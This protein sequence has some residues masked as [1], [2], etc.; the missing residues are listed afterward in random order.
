[1]AQDMTKLIDKLNDLIALD[2]DAVSAYE[3]AIERIKA[4]LV[5]ERLR[6]FQADHE[7]HIRDLT[8]V[9]QSYGG[10]ARN[11]RDAKGFF[12]Q[13]FTAITS[14]MG[15][16]SALTAMKSN[17]ELTNRT[18]ERALEEVWPESIRTIIERNREDERVHLAFVEQTLAA[19][20]VT[21]A[22]SVP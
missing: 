17:E 14:M 7:R 6:A 18:Y 2:L 4:V 15:D 9:V 12:I 19:E 11:T 13:A 8:S 10:K 22:P 5:R 1:M 3:S 21:P 16:K 20:R